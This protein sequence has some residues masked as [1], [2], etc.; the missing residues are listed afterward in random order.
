MGGDRIVGDV[1]D[2][3][4]FLDDLLGLNIMVVRGTKDAFFDAMCD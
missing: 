3:T 4:E 2:F 1:D